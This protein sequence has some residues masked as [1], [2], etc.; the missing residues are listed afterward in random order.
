MAMR[1]EVVNDL[2][3]DENILEND[4]AKILDEQES[5]DNV[6]K[7]RWNWSKE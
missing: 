5:M 7:G 4:T 1:V 2:Y 6:S 3:V